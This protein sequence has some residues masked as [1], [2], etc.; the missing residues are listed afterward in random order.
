MSYDEYYRLQIQNNNLLNG[1]YKLQDTVKNTLEKNKNLESKNKKLELKN[2]N[3]ETINK[4]LET[5]NKELTI[6]L[7]YKETEHTKLVNVYRCVVCMES[8]KNIILQPCFHYSLCSECL[9]KVDTCPICRD[10]I[11]LY[12]VV[13]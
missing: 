1:L 12:N 5:T 8:P 9:H 10:P 6:K 11:D 4:N 7:K 3:L 13:F 2:K